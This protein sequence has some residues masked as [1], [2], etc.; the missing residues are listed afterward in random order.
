MSTYFRATS[1]AAGIRSRFLGTISAN[2]LVDAYLN[3]FSSGRI[4]IIDESSLAAASLTGG[5]GLLM[6]VDVAE[7]LLS[8][9]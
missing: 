5:L 8:P 4:I 9:I 2:P 3:L 7:L 6:Q 1:S